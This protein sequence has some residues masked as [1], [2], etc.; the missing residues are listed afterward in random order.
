MRW[1][2]RGDQGTIL[3]LSE[4]SPSAMCV[5]RV[6]FIHGLGG[7]GL[8]PLNRLADHHNIDLQGLDLVSKQCKK[9]HILFWNPNVSTLNLENIEGKVR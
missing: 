1:C 9:N 2:E 3:R 8:Y 6:G 4:F 7:R 5:P